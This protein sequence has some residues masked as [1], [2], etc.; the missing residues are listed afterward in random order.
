MYRA[1]DKI[2][3]CLKFKKCIGPSIK[4]KIFKIWKICRELDEIIKCLKF[5]KYIGH[6]VKFKKNV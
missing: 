2:R 5:E 4:L 6:S 3:N 1:L